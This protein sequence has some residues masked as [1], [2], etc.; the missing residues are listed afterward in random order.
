MVQ[1][2]FFSFFPDHAN[3]LVPLSF[4]LIIWSTATVNAYT[5]ASVGTSIPNSL[6]ILIG[7]PRITSTSNLLPSL[8][9]TCMLL[10]IPGRLCILSIKTS[11]SPY[12]RVTPALL[13]TPITSRIKRFVT[14]TLSF[15]DESHSCV[16]CC[17]SVVRGFHATW[18]VSITSTAW[19][20]GWTHVP[21]NFLPSLDLNIV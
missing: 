6:A 7:V 20:L 14:C 5:V 10:S 13:A 17:V 16:F 3:Q 11:T 4:C 1:K 21:N 2:L 19:I 15:E 8:A 9:S 18:V 12:S